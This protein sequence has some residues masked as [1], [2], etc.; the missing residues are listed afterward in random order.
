V[1]ALGVQM[2][3]VLAGMVKKVLKILELSALLAEKVKYKKYKLLY[4]CLSMEVLNYW[5]RI[6][7]N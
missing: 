5:I 4:L 2:V 7:R 3:I 1:V 6:Y